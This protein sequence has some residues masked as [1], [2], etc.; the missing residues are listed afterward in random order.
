MYGSQNLSDEQILKRAEEIRE[1]QLQKQNII[2]KT[3]FEQNKQ[4]DLELKQLEIAKK[5]KEINEQKQYLEMKEQNIKQKEENLIWKSQTLNE[6]L[7]IIKNAKPASGIVDQLAKVPQTLSQSI[8]AQMAEEYQYPI[9]KVIVKDEPAIT[10]NQSHLQVKH[11]QQSPREYS[12]PFVPCPVI[13]QQFQPLFPMQQ[14]QQMAIPQVVPVSVFT[15]DPMQ[16]QPYIAPSE[17]VNA[18]I[19]Q[20]PPPIVP[21][22]VDYVQPLIL[23][24]NSTGKSV[25]HNN[26]FQQEYEKL[27]RAPGIDKEMLKQA[28]KELQQETEFKE[29]AKLTVN[30]NENLLQNSDLT[31]LR[32]MD[33]P[34]RE[35][36]RKKQDLIDRVNTSFSR[37]ESKNQS[38][39]RFNNIPSDLEAQKPIQKPRST[40]KITLD[41]KKGAQ[42]I[43]SN[44]NT[45]ESSFISKLKLKNET[46]IQTSPVNQ[47]AQPNEVVIPPPS[48]KFR[49]ILEKNVQLQKQK[50]EKKPFWESKA[51]SSMIQTDEVY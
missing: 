12:P 46:Q 49:Q 39:I 20:T 48:L 3:N 41:N 18:P 27:S 13:Q 45:Q 4:N 16:F 35:I 5:E 14:M 17:T 34:V 11:V 36:L 1:K 44:Q 7:E 10:Y 15:P 42:N 9:Q 51:A 26:E 2:I 50:T 31:P 29:M 33:G 23:S 28:I 6:Q 43:N 40:V 22:K 37:S 21:V 30:N 24:T 8:N 47:F 19:H 25:V 32:N 38:K